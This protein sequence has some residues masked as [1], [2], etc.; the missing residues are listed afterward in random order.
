MERTFLHR[1]GPY[2]SK[3]RLLGRRFGIS[4]GHLGSG[5]NRGARHAPSTALAPRSRSDHRKFANLHLRRQDRVDNPHLGRH[6]LAGQACG[7][8]AG[9]FGSRPLAADRPLRDR[10]ASTAALRQ[11]T[12]YGVGPASTLC[13]PRGRDSY[14]G[15]S[16][17]MHTVL[18]K[19][20]PVKSKMTVELAHFRGLMAT[21]AATLDLCQAASS[22]VGS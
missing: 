4:T 15:I 6:A 21:E 11:S 19:P 1:S 22:P 17:S 5:L 7:S 9:R 2:Q 13:C 3:R 10:P 18:E 20:R 14:G 12:W 8:T 16:A